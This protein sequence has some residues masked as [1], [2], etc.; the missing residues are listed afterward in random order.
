MFAYM[1]VEVGDHDDI[2]CQDSIDGGGTLASGV[3]SMVGRH[4][5]HWLTRLRRRRPGQ[6]PVGAVGPY[7]GG[8]MPPVKAGWGGGCTGCPPE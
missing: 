7:I 8:A 4:A 6:M 5:G 2:G 1:P 3:W